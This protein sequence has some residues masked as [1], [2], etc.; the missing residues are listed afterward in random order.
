MK[1]HR[2]REGDN[3]IVTRG[4]LK[5]LKSDLRREWSLMLLASTPITGA[6]SGW[7][8]AHSS[9]GQKAIKTGMAL[10]HHFF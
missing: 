7:I 8:A 4:D 5:E 6:V 3:R 10:V 2:E 9:A 1:E